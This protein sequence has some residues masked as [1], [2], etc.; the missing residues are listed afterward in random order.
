[1]WFSLQAR[2]PLPNAPAAVLQ[3]CWH[4]KACTSAHSQLQAA[5]VQCL[6]DIRAVIWYSVGQECKHDFF[7]SFWQTKQGHCKQNTIM[8]EEIL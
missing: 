7:F 1:M 8:A 3:M 6:C 2:P 5:P 4:C